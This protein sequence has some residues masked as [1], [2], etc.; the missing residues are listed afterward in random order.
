M[1]RLLAPHPP[2][3]QVIYPGR[4]LVIN[5]VS[6]SGDR[7]RV[8]NIHN[9]EV[10]TAAIREL[11]RL[12]A[13]AAESCREVFLMTGDWNMSEMNSPTMAVESISAA[14]RRSK[15]SAERRR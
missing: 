7:F 3:V 6:S 13:A 9:F 15:S 10:P 2:E 1:A 4:V 5:F 11:A 8:G 12:A 14:T